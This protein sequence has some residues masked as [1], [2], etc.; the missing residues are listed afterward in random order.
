MYWELKTGAETG[1]DY[2]TRWMISNES[3]TDSSSADQSPKGHPLTTNLHE[4]K[5]RYIVPVDLNAILEKNARILAKYSDE[6]LDDQVQAAFY[7]DKSDSLKEA[8]HKVLWSE[9]MGVWLDYDIMNN[10]PRETFICSNFFPLWTESMP[11]ASREEQ[12]RRAVDYF[13]ALTLDKYAGGVPTTFTYSGQQWDFPNCWPPLEHMMVQ[14]LENTGLDKAKELAYKVA[15]KRVLG[16]YNNFLD[17]GH[18]FEKYDASNMMRIGGGGEYEIQI[19][20]GWTNGVVLDFLNMYGD[21]L[22]QEA[23]S[24]RLN[25][26]AFGQSIAG[27]KPSGETAQKQ[28]EEN[29]QSGERDAREP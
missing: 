6:V 13:A 8:I 1:W 28:V 2:S 18:M 27:K 20:F 3:A 16:A 23:D 21:R 17:K 29:T 7:K 5:A 26:D 14:G 24:R 25:V 10:K 11:E 19:G 12:S 22:D 4:T 15:S 9:S